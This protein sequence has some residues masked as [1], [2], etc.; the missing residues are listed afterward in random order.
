MP[1]YAELW[2][3][4]GSVFAAAILTLIGGAVTRGTVPIEMRLLVGWGIACLVLTVWGMTMP[5]S[6][7]LPAWAL[8]AVG[9][10]SLLRPTLRPGAADLAAL[11]R[12]VLLS[13]PLLAIIVSVRPSLP[14]TFLNLLPNAAYLV[15]HGVLPD[16]DNVA[17]ISI[18]PALPYNQQIEVFLASLITPELP[19][20]GL[21]HFN[22]FVQLAFALLLARLIAPDARAGSPGWTELAIGLA[23]TTLANPGFMPKVALASM[24]EPTS[25]VT[26][27]CAAWLGIRALETF[28]ERRS[29][30]REL[31][32]MAAVLLA[33][34]N[35]RQSNVAL[36]G[37]LAG[38]LALLALI[39]RR[40]AKLRAWSLLALA[41]LPAALLY[42]CWRLYVLGHFHESELKLLPLASWQADA[43]PEILASMGT[44]ILHRSLLFVSLIAAGPLAYL[45]WRGRRQWS[46]GSRTLALVLIMFLAFNVFLIFAYVA[47]FGDADGRQAHSYFRYNSHLSLLMMLALTLAGSERFRARPI[48]LRPLLA[49]WAPR[50]AVTLAL[51]APVLFLRKVRFDLAMPQPVLWDLSKAFAGQLSDGERIAVIA[52]GDNGTLLLT[53]RG[54]LALTQPRLS[55]LELVELVDGDAKAL[56]GLSDRGFKKA[57]VTCA[58]QM[59]LASDAPEAVLL[60]RGAGGWSVAARSAYRIRPGKDWMAQ[61]P[62]GPFCVRQQ[63]TSS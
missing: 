36:F 15:D 34:I 57:I 42:A 60:E 40:I 17:T 30:R 12:L 22:V 54:Y 25:E 7:R 61:F 50:I 55:G 31:A 29:A 52:P 18:F 46:Q 24:G 44:I 1:S 62:A 9:C 6:L 41:M 58:A 32:L 37:S 35:I 13:L 48:P 26:L 5:L 63:A 19:A 23:L 2:A 4:S 20:G 43:I 8:V 21:V 10:A 3:F 45:A 39:D 53:L 51:L 49:V 38:G 11:G 56:D 28:S 27:A 59:G 16:N 47:H 14:D 33:F